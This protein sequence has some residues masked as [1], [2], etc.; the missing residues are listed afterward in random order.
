VTVLAFDLA[1]AQLDPRKCHGAPEYDWDVG[2]QCG[3]VDYSKRMHN[4]CFDN[5]HSHV[6]RCLNIME[7]GIFLVDLRPGGAPRRGPF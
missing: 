1:W 7:V 2:V 4:L 5:C 6:A 3:C